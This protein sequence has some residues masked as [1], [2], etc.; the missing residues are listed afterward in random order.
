MLTDLVTPV[1]RAA[2][3]LLAH[4]APPQLAAGFALGMVIGL[5]PKGNLIALSLCVLLFSLRVNK[6][7]ALVAAVLFSIF[8]RH[9]DAFAA[10]THKVGL[11]AL[12]AEPLQGLYAA[13]YRLPLGPWLEFNNTVVMGSLLVGLYTAYPVYWLTRVALTRFFCERGAPS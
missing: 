4:D 3:F 7:L 10:F 12:H 11:Y 1:R 9:A 6:G 8:G 13:V 5:L 2:S